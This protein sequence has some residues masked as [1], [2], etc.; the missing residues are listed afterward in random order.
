MAMAALSKRRDTASSSGGG[1][2]AGMITQR[3]GVRLDLPISI[4][5]A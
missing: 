2:A 1:G 4:E 3:G 5:E